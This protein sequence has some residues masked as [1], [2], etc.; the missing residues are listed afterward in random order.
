MLSVLLNYDP[1]PEEAVQFY[2]ANIIMAMEYAHSQDIIHRD[3]KPENIL[4]RADGYLVL[5]DFGLAKHAP[6]GRAYTLC[7]TPNYMVSPTHPQH[8]PLL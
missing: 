3:M 1:L 5:A 8:V 4:M 7:G 2:C 6:S